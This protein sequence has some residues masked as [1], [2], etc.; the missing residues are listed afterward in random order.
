MNKL[1]FGLMRLPLTVPGDEKS[2]DIEQTK[3]MVDLYLSRGY[4]YFDTAHRYHGGMS[5]KALRLALTDRYPREAYEL[6][7]KITLV[8]FIKSEAEQ[9][10]FFADQLKICGVTWF[11]NYLVHNMN[12][13]TYP[14]AREYR[15]F[16][17]LQSLKDRGLCKRTGFSF[18]GSPDLLETILTEHPEI[19]LVQ[20]QLNYLDWLDAGVQS[21]KCYEI[22]VRH[23]KKVLCM[24]SIKGGNLIDLPD[25]AAKLLREACPGRSFAYWALAFCATLPCTERVLSGMSSLEQLDANTRDMAAFEPLT[26]DE[27]K[28]LAEAAEIIRS[29][30]AIGCTGCEYCESYCPKHIAIPAYFALYNAEHRESVNY[31]HASGMYY[32]AISQTKGKASDCLECGACESHCPQ[33]LPIRKYL[34][35]VKAFF[36]K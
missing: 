15:T 26:E 27:L 30:T 17:F 36:E 25:P 21:K 28:V 22:A 5:E 12:G 14:L 8:P 18:H 19:D 7:N 13:T 29:N 16:D 24:E 32:K 11:D 23:G 4:R 2:V 35:D 20:L 6:T 33:H 3:Q 9:E 34:K 31:V 1:G 10:G